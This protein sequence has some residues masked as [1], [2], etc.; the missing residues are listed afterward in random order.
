M[1]KKR[2]YVILAVI[3]AAMIIAAIALAI[4]Q[5]SFF[6]HG[7]VLTVSIQTWSYQIDDNYNFHFNV[8]VKNSGPSKQNFTI[9]CKV[10]TDSSSYSSSQKYSLDSGITTTHVIRVDTVPN[11]A[12]IQKVECWIS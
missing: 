6:N 7:T 1:E 9:Y 11:K 5:G 4:T 2:L 12:H 10:T 8:V 3:A